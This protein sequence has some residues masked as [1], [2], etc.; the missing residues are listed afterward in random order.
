MRR[1]FFSSFF[2]VGLVSAVCVAVISDSFLVYLPAAPAS[3]DASAND[4]SSDAAENDPLASCSPSPSALVGHL[5]PVVAELVL[6]VLALERPLLVLVVD[7]WCCS[8]SRSG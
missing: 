3:D 6:P 4:A 8:S 5:E 2:W 1:R 7:R